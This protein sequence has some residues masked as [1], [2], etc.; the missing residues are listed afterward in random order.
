MSRTDRDKDKDAVPKEDIDLFNAFDITIDLCK[1]AYEPQ[2]LGK[3]FLEGEFPV[4][5]RK[6]GNTLYIAFR[7]TRNDFSTLQS[8]L[9]SIR[10]MIIDCSVGDILGENTSL[11]EFSVFKSRLNDSSLTGHAGFMKELS[12]Y[13]LDIL[14]KIKSYY[15]FASKVVFT[16]HSAYCSLH[17]CW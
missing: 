5:F 14:E 9:E 10:N 16:G 3:D 2:T 11:A 15:N 1:E 4:I 7:G 8:S 6:I 17:L 12:K 13:Y